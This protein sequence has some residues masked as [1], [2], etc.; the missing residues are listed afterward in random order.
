L[1]KIKKKKLKDQDI[2]LIQKDINQQKIYIDDLNKLIDLRKDSTKRTFDIAEKQTLQFI[3]EVDEFQESIAEQ[4][5]IQIQDKQ[6]ELKN[7]IENFLTDQRKSKSVKT[8]GQTMASHGGILGIR[9]AAHA[10][11][12]QQGDRLR[13]KIN[14]IFGIG[15][16][17]K[18]HEN[19]IE[20]YISKY[21]KELEDKEIP[22]P[23]VDK[24]SGIYERNLRSNMSRMVKE[25]GSL[26]ES[27]LA[28]IAEKSKTTDKYTTN[29][30]AES[31]ENK[32]VAEAHATGGNLSG[33]DI[34]GERGLE[35][36]KGN[37]VLSPEGNTGNMSKW[38]TAFKEIAGV[39]NQKK[40]PLEPH[41][42]KIKNDINSIKEL[43]IKEFDYIQ[44]RDEDK[45]FARDSKEA[46]N[47]KDSN[48]VKDNVEEA[49][50]KKD[51]GMLSNI[52]SGMVG[53]TVGGALAK[54]AISLVPAILPAVIS[55]AGIT[56][57]GVAAY[58]IYKGVKSMI[59]A[60][61]I[62]KNSALLYD[63]AIK[64]EYG[65]EFSKATSD[66]GMPNFGRSIENYWGYWNNTVKDYLKIGGERF[67]GKKS[68]YEWVSWIE[69]Q[70]KLKMLGQK[71]WDK[72]DEYGKA[73]NIL[74]NTPEFQE[75]F[76]KELSSQPTLAIPFNIK[77][78]PPVKDAIIQDKKITR[79]DKDDVVAIGTDLKQSK[80]GGLSQT[81]KEAMKDVSLDIIN[82]FN[83]REMKQITLDMYEKTIAVW[84][85]SEANQKKN[86]SA[87]TIISNTNNNIIGG[88]SAIRE[89]YI[90]VELDFVRY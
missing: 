26:G 67:T 39:K 22:Q 70:A 63:K 56:M 18:H 71:Y 89:K 36:V 48:I 14:K 31:T 68:K 10:Y 23:E 15:E 38:F 84:Q 69:D 72:D 62:E 17:E 90:P 49:I 43:M 40:N 87:N 29:K 54:L 46:I 37:E 60:D 52:I 34:V 83:P 25:K 88:N 59:E 78:N 9:K 41:I 75:K 57:V 1:H 7:I 53:G 8:F 44:E 45:D 74:V 80:K 51:G 77:E 85:Q 66:M 32:V 30:K 28:N 20:E 3:N 4:T 12:L 24:L 79:F 61:E 82:A 76:K 73:I 50:V 47:I 11:G 81:L 19:V 64:Q 13:K 27:D 35:I 21:Q 16:L 2:L 6:K 86:A 33:L 65:E 5:G 42:I 55:A 58:S